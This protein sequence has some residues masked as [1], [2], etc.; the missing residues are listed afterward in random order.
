MPRFPEHSKFFRSAKS[1]E[2]DS[3]LLCLPN[4]ELHAG[5]EVNLATTVHENSFLRLAAHSTLKQHGRPPTKVGGRPWMA[6]RTPTVSL[7]PTGR[8]ASPPKIPI[9]LST[10]SHANSPCSRCSRPHHTGWTCGPRSAPPPP[11]S[12]R[13][14]RTSPGSRSPS[15]TARRRVHRQTRTHGPTR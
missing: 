3:H 5:D 14:A 2:E 4:A 15:A 9:R 6:L 11:R 12:P 1:G 13:T 8:W 10:G 7:C